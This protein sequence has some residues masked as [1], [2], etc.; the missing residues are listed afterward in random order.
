MADTQSKVALSLGE[1]RLL[2]TGSQILL[3]FQ[4]RAFFE[5]GFA[6][7]SE[8]VQNLRLVSLGLMLVT[9]LLLIWPV[10]FHEI[11]ERGQLTPKLQGFTTSVMK[12]ALLPFALAS[13]IDV[14]SMSSLIAG[15]HIGLAA[16]TGTA[17]IALFLWYG[18]PYIVRAR[19]PN[20]GGGGK[21]SGE[22]KVPG[23]DL[24]KKIETVLNDCR[25]VV[26]GSQALLGF[27]LSGILM[28]K[29]S[30]LP[31]L[32]QRVHLLSLLMVLLSTLFLMAPAAYH[33]IVERG[34]ATERFWRFARRMLLTAMVW[35]PAGLATE[36][37]VILRVA[38]GSVAFSL[39]ISL[40]VLAAFYGL[41]FGY[42]VAV[43]LRRA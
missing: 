39:G 32:S 7:L 40:L 29:F 10:G 26:P 3:G 5:P 34:E 14:Y 19:H 18:W 15:E 11:T 12:T 24:D 6:R 21:Q 23:T 35:L 8:A 28:D 43:K 9:I 42:T 37:F 41:W 33:R 17:S 31:A 16:G 30:R 38:T 27:Q 36:F 1:A 13:G 20:G 25:V 22:K 4:Y 2:I